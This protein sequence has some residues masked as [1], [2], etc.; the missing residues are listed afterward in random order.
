MPPP[1][2]EPAISA[3][4]RPQIHVLDRAATG[5]GDGSLLAPNLRKA[6]QASCAPRIFPWGGGGG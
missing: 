1:D 4:E 2:F 5:I 3:S 6:K